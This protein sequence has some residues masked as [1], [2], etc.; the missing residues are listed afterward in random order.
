M[1]PSLLWARGCLAFQSWEKYQKS[2][3]ESQLTEGETGLQ[4]TCQCPRPSMVSGWAGKVR[5]PY[6]ALRDSNRMT[7]PRDSRGSSRRIQLGLPG[8]LWTWTG[9]DDGRASLAQEPLL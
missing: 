8:G 7:Q 5:S 1:L 6:P 2:P 3:S 9:K 4:Q